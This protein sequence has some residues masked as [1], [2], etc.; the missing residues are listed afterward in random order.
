MSEKDIRNIGFLTEELQ[1]LSIIKNNKDCVVFIDVFDKDG[2]KSKE[3]IFRLVAEKRKKIPVDKDNSDI[4]EG[5]LLTID[6]TN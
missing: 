1:I 3:D 6:F 5:I 4:I 2:G